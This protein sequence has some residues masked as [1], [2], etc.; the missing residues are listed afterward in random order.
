MPQHSILAAIA[1]LAL[2][3]CANPTSVEMPL[4]F[5]D[6]PP[7][8][9]IASAELGSIILEKARYRTADALIADADIVWTQGLI[10]VTVTMP[11]GLLLAKRHDVEY[12]YYSS[13]R[14]TLRVPP[15]QGEVPFPDAEFRMKNDVLRG[16]Y[17]SVLPPDPSFPLVTRANLRKT[18]VR[19]FDAT[20][21]Q[22]QLVF[23]GR[24]GDTLQFQYRRA[25]GDRTQ[26]EAIQNVEWNLKDGAIMTF[27]GAKIQILDITGTQLRYRVSSSFPDETETR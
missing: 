14:S 18:Q 15:G 19:L 27:A 26:P 6:E 23:R 16:P 4:T 20:G 2:M 10:G 13:N 22:K 25:F 9:Q 1:A 8:G 11:A 12:T 7:S 17:G 21:F 3:A 5:I 24:S